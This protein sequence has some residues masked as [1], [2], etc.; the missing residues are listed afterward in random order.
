VIRAGA[1]VWLCALASVASGAA[2]A[3]CPQVRT[4]LIPLPVYSTLPNEGSTWGV[5]PVFLRVCDPEGRTQSILAPSATWN[6]VIHWTGTMRF[7]HYPSDEETLIFVGSLSTRINSNVLVQWRNVPRPAGALTREIELRWERSAFYRFFGLGPDT[8][9]VSETSY[10][11]IRAHANFRAGLNLGG[12]WN[13]G[14]L[15]YL[16]HDDVQDLGVPGL[17]LSRR[18]F[19]DTPGMEGATTLGQQLDLRYDTRPAGDF[20]EK[21]I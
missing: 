2:A 5:M 16:H 20:S 6:D 13:A 8:S 9:D 18:V 1:A 11:R 4:E 21:G 15:L 10:T 19:A 14:V 7:F 3:E 12:R 17:P